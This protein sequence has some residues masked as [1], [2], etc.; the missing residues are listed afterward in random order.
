M[1]DHVGVGADSVHIHFSRCCL[2]PI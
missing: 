1:D 2:P